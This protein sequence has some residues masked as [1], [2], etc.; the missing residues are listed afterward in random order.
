MKQPLSQEAFKPQGLERPSIAGA[1]NDDVATERHWRR[2][3]LDQL[4]PPPP[5][6]FD[7]R[8]MESLQLAIVIESP[9]TPHYIGRFVKPEEVMRA[10]EETVRRLQPTNDQGGN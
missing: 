2:A 8:A 3:L 5:S 10:Y 6:S 7:S 4:I 9:G 1:D